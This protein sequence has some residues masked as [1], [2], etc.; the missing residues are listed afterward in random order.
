MMKEQSNQGLHCLLFGQHLLHALL[1]GK[2]FVQNL[3]KITAVFL[4]CLN[5]LIF[6]ASSWDYTY[7][8]GDQRRLRQACAVSPE[9]S[10]FAHM[11]YG[12]R[13]RVQPKIRHL[14]PLD[15]CACTFEEWVYGG[16]KMCV[17][18]T[19]QTMTSL[20]WQQHSTVVPIVI[21]CQGI[22]IKPWNHK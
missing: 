18:F 19:D 12:N 7:H 10:L 5:F 3:G 4:G 14:A 1:Y 11:K 21:S 9:P 17:L 22:I 8:I 16:R 6:R 20:H 15:G 13:R 2:T